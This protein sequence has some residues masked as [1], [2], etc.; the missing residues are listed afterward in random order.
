M[1]IA[2]V[3]LVFLGGDLLAYSLGQ[4]PT[5]STV[6]GAIPGTTMTAS[7][8]N[9]RVRDQLATTGLDGFHVDGISAVH[10]NPPKTWTSGATFGCDAYAPS[11][12]VIGRYVATVRPSN[13]NGRPQWTGKWLAENT[14]DPSSVTAG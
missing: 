9:S 8:L 3:L 12:Q 1:L 4:H 14:P 11:G 10:C 13:G 7:Q 5:P 6:P 2:V